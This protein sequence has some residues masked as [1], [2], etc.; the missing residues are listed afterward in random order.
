MQKPESCT[1]KAVKSWLEG[2]SEGPNGRFAPSF[3]GLMATRLDGED[4]LI[5]LHPSFG[6]DWLTRLVRFPYVRAFALVRIH[7]VRSEF[8]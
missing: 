3:S 2:R 6:N 5:A 1:V 7:E 4:D 8:R